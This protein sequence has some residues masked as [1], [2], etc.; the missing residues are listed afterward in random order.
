MGEGGR[1]DTRT[2]LR[3]EL[4]E[5]P[6]RQVCSVHNHLLAV[7]YSKEAGGVND[8]S[9]TIR[10]DI[11]GLLTQLHKR[12]SLV[13]KWWTQMPLRLVE[14]RFDI[15]GAIHLITFLPRVR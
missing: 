9:S 11:L 8:T 2:T 12:D 13:S 10:C 14:E 4:N 7:F 6:K 3:G 15:L 1:D 5:K